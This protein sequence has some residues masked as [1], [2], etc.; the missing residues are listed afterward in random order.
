[1]MANR[2]TIQFGERKVFWTLSDQKI[3]A[4]LETLVSMFGP[5]QEDRSGD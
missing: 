5:A 4:L 2:V 1:M 3:I